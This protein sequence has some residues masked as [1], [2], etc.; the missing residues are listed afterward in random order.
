LFVGLI[1]AAEPAAPASPTSV[2]IL[3]LAGE[4]E[5]LRA[6]QQLWAAAAT[7]LTLNPG[8]RF[9][10]KANSR[11]TLRLSDRSQIRVGELS[12]FQALAPAAPGASPAHKLWRGLLYFFHRDKPGTFRFDTPGASAAVRGTEFVLAV[13]DAGRTLLTLLDG[14]VLLSN[15][16]GQAELRTGQQGA[17]EPGRAPTATALLSAQLLDSVQ[18]G[19][20]YPGVLHLPELGLSEAESAALR[21]SLAAWREGDLL[22]ALRRYPESR[23][24]NS[25]AE[26]V[27]RAGLLLA[28][29][30]VE[31]ARQ[32]LETPG[33]SAQLDFAEALRRLIA[34]VLGREVSTSATPDTASALLAESYVHQS[35]S[36]IRPALNAARNAVRRAP[37]FAFGW[38]R[39]AELEFGFGRISK[40]EAAVNKAL[41][42]APRHAQALALKG[43]LAAARHDTAAAIGW[44]DRAI[45]LDGALGNAWLGRGLCKIRR[46]Q[47]AAGLDDLQTAATLEP[48]RALLRSYLGKAYEQT[49]DTSLATRELELAVRL[50]ENDPTPW[51]YRA[52]LERGRNR[53]NPAVAD[54]ERSLALNDRR[55]VYRSRLLLDQD[56][57]VR[58][59][60]L[61]GVY[62]SAGLGDASLREAAR[63]V[64]DDYANPSAHLFLSESYNA[65]RDP[66][67]FNLRH[68][69]VWFN[70]RLLASL[71]GPV[72]SV[73]LSQHLSQQ[74]Y[75]RLFERDRFGLA[76][77]TEYRSDGQRRQQASQF[78]VSGP[79]SYAL[80]LDYQ[81]NDGVR[82][83]NEL[84]RIEWYSTLKYQ[85]TPQDSALL[86]VKYQDYHSGDNFQTYAVPDPSCSNCFSGR[87]SFFRGARRFFSYD[88]TQS[89]LVVAGWHH[90]W[91]PGVHSLLLGGRLQNDQRFSDRSVPEP[92]VFRD[93]AL[94][95]TSL[96]SDN[97]DVRHR[98][99]LEIYT[100]ELN[101]IFQTERH[102][103]VLGGRAQAGEFQ[104]R[105]RLTY[106]GTNAGLFLTPAAD[107]RANDGFFRGSAYAYYTLELPTRL[108]LTGGVAYDALR[109]PA[110]FR[111][112]PV[113]D[114]EQTHHQ[115]SPKAA[116]VWN[117]FAPVTLRGIYA[118]SLGGA[119]LDES[120]RLEPTQLAGFPQSFRTIISES[121]AGSVAGAE[122]ETLG[123]GLDLKLP[124]HTY[125]GA[126]I[127]RLTS[128]VRQTIGTFD[129]IDF[130]PPIVAGSTRQHLDYEERGVS[131]YVSKLF[132]DE[133]SAGAQYRFTWSDLTQRL[134]E[135]SAAQPGAR[136][137]DRAELHNVNLFLLYNHASGFFARAEAQ[138]YWQHNAAD[139]ALLGESE[140]LQQVNLWAGW[141]CPRQRGEVAFGVLN[142]N[143][144]DYILNPVT[145]YSELPRERVFAARLL[146]NF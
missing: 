59:S 140:S 141:R 65:L 33:H 32:L 29:G 96:G 47:T 77:A 2:F 23:A 106:A 1:R 66:T 24:P 64:S 49:R 7:N 136:R 67:R 20:Y 53:I 134:P 79:F 18:W 97:F 114:G 131:A 113:S 73:P 102:T 120:F 107:T 46:G 123:G 5:V 8:D 16:A 78:G 130:N 19:L 52:L 129:Y 11:A 124:A 99:E 17:A 61:A 34:S 72:G 127:E 105:S 86:L 143:D 137:I 37:D 27:Y 82:P 45:A 75:S 68:E 121:L 43:F 122:Y 89:P 76:S 69:T 28:V 39:V 135:I 128:R 138:V 110:N 35:R 126:Q 44:F 9:R 104:T 36:D 14:E 146:F 111:A 139:S 6:G 116:L 58:S 98:S 118:R 93:A 94:A 95:V 50:D 40:A 91:A 30:Q 12:E 26:R 145:P 81:H 144:A 41:A 132:G 56:R 38:A 142:L 80:D 119:S 55:G 21:D 84:D 101:Q 3:E 48:Q 115:I 83:N 85:F 125:A 62:Q 31:P 22:E 133:W 51:L 42:L 4:A 112:P 88:E 74:E 71:L 92:I 109:Y 63:A 87:V 103:L 57:A 54:L 70:E 90:Q 108:R 15:N 13:N 60:S 117:P 100:G 25:D 10:T